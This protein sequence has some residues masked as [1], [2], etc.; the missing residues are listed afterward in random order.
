MEANVTQFVPLGVL[1][2][3]TAKLP[4]MSAPPIANSE[5][6]GPYVSRV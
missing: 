4:W 5:L 2:T 1:H 6:Y 3:A